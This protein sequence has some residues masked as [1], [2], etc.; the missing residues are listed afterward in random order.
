MYQFEGHSR[1]S[2]RKVSF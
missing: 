1:K 2:G